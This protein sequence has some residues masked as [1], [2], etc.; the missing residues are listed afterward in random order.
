MNYSTSKRAKGTEVYYSKVNNKK[1]FS[2][3]N[4]KIFATRMRNTIVNDLHT[5]NRGIKQAG[6]VVIK[7]NTVPAV[8]VE[9]GFVSNPR[10]R[11]K[12]KTST[13][14][15]KAAKSLYKVFQK[16][17]KNTLQPEAEKIS[18]AG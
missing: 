7:R 10:E 5:T 16:L 12:L 14:Q 13:Y 11:G 1:S 6:F 2:G 17:S 9:L 4:S 15:T 18:K 8:L 3:L